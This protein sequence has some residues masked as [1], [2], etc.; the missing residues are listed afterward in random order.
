MD[1]HGIL[2]KGDFETNNIKSLDGV[3]VVDIDDSTGKHTFKT[4][5]KIT[6]FTTPSGSENEYVL[7]SDNNL[8]DCSFSYRSIPL[9]SKVLFESDTAVIGYTL[10][11]NLDDALVYIEKGSAAG[12]EPGNAFKSGSTWDIGTQ[13]THTHSI[14][15]ESAHNHSTSNATISSTQMP[16]HS[17]Y[18]CSGPAGGGSYIQF[19]RSDGGKYDYHLYSAAHNYSATDSTYGRRGVSG[20]S[21]AGGGHNHSN[22]VATGSHN[23]GGNTVTGPTLGSSWRPYGRNFTKQQKT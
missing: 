12:G 1:F 22:V 8:G 9:N 16:S 15:T 14:T 3:E 20:Y 4:D 2:M 17:H 23:H 18:F 6:G 19:I 7:Q 11:T 13:L 21:G 10:R 5:I